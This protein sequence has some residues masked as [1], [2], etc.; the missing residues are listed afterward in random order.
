MRLI[1]V[2]VKDRLD[3]KFGCFEMFGFD[4]MLNSA[5]EPKLIEINVNPALFLDTQ[6]QA[7]IL[8]K[9]VQDTVTIAHE[10]HKPHQK[11]STKAQIE[12]IFAKNNQ[13][14]YTVLHTEE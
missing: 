12:E 11:A 8:P 5:L 3:S 14:G 10:I 7:D 4:F 2:T 6:V 9:L 13:L 1:F